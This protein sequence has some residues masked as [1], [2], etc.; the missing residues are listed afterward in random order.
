MIY[1]G[2]PYLP[3]VVTELK[4]RIYFARV[5]Y[6]S[7]PMQFELAFM[8]RKGVVK[9]EGLGDC[10]YK[11]Y[12]KLHYFALLRTRIIILGIITYFRILCI[13]FYVVD[14][15]YQNHWTK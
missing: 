6:N 3:N 2:E 11:H 1:N 9:G 13:Q 4:I 5:R 7:I 12:L 10:I 15:T 8:R 14:N